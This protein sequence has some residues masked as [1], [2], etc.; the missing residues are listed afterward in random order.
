ML[1]IIVLPFEDKGNL[2]TERLERCPA[3]FAF[4]DPELDQVKHV[5]V[6]AWSLHKTQTMR[7]IADYYAK[8]AEA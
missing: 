3:A 7:R 1:Q 2:E 5:P 4:Y 8:K 6:C